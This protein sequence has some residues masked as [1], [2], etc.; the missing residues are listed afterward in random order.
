[1]LNDPDPKL[2]PALA[3]FTASA[4]QPNQRNVAYLTVIAAY[5]IMYTCAELAGLQVNFGSFVGYYLIAAGLGLAAL[6]LTTRNISTMRNVAEVFLLNAFLF[7][8]LLVISYAAMALDGAAVLKPALDGIDRTLGWTNDASLLMQLQNW[9][10]KLFDLEMILL[11]SMM[12]F[13]GYRSRAYRSFGILFLAAIACVAVA[14]LL[15]GYCGFTARWP[16]YTNLIAMNTAAVCEFGQTMLSTSG[17]SELVLS[18]ANGGKLVAFPTL[19]GAFAA[20]GAWLSWPSATLRRIVVPFNAIMI[21]CGLALGIN[22]G[23]G[24]VAGAAT[25]LVVI[26]VASHGL[27]GAISGGIAFVMNPLGRSRALTQS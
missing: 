7:T 23:I 21:L 14:T 18:A 13:L 1:M 16:S 10:Y 8:P 9:S 17:S 2:A 12:V 15:P 4:L 22:Y 3:T 5:A 20:M 26:A 24:I 27:R 25:A 11:P 6:F 19:F